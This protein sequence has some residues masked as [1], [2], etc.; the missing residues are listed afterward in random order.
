[1]YLLGIDTSTNACSCAIMKDG[2]AICELCVNNQKTHSST[3]CV[4]IEQ[5]LAL[6]GLS[7][8]QID[9]IACV[10][11]PGSFT[12]LRIG[13]CTAKGLAFGE[14]KPCYGIDTLDCL[15]VGGRYF[16]GLVC[17]I[18]DARSEQV[19]GAVFEN[20]KKIQEDFAG[21]LEEYL[22]KLEGKPTMFV[23]DGALAYREKIKSCL[24]DAQ[25]GSE[26]QCYPRAAAA[27]LLAH[28]AG[29]Q[30]AKSLYEL[31]PHYLRKS[32]AERLRHH[33]K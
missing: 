1:M 33:D 21:P 14:K 28:E 2:K 16:A 7:M 15:A 6:T 10:V 18:L 23:G 4:L 19:F 24:P 11:G 12:G 31:T 25:F 30:G 32:Q 20:G 13:V 17:P 26:Q 9:A 29:E 27:C 3:L 5:A 8:N 22:Q